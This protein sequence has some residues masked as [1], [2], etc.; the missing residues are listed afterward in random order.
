[1]AGTETTKYE[2][3]AWLR[4]KGSFAKQMQRQARAVPKVDA[5]LM[6]AQQNAK[7]L[8]VELMRGPVEAM[9]RMAKWSAVIGGAAGAFAMKGLI[10]G[11]LSFNKQMEDARLNLATMF[12]M[13]GIADGVIGQAAS[14]SEKWSTNVDIARAAMREFMVLQAQTPAGAQDLVRIYQ[15]S[16]AG[17]A[18]ANKNVAKHT[19]FVAEWSVLAGALDGDIQQLGADLGRM[20][21]GQAGAELRTWQIFKSNILEAAKGAGVVKKEMQLGDKWVQSWNKNLTAEQRF[22]VLQRFIGQAG[23]ELRKA[24]GESMG[25]LISTTKATMNSLKGVLTTPMF[26]EFRQFLKRITDASS[27]VF[28][29]EAMRDWVKIL[30]FFG[31]L[32]QGAAGKWLG[33]IERG[34]VVLRENWFEIADTVYKAFQAGALLIK[35]ALVAGAT[36]LALGAGARVVG[37]GAGAARAGIGGFRK[38]AGAIGNVRGGLDMGIKRGFLGKGRGLTGMFGSL[39]NKMFADQNV[40]GARKLAL[41]VTRMGSAFMS[42]LVIVIPLVAV[43]AALGVAV[44]AV[45]VIVAGM[46]AFL[47]DNWRLIASEIATAMREGKIKIGEVLIAAFKLWNGLKAVGQMFLGSGK[48]VDFTNMMLGVMRDVINLVTQSIIFFLDAG[49][50]LVHWFGDFT[51]ILARFFEMTASINEFA[52]SIGMGMGSAGED[53]KKQREWAKSLR[54]TTLQADNFEMRLGDIKRQFQHFQIRGLP[55][56]DMKKIADA[57]KAIADFFDASAKGKKPKVPVSGVHVENMYN[58]WDLRNTDPDRLMGAFLPKIEQLADKRVQSYEQ[59][60]QGV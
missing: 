45:A 31:T 47:I 29:T 49:M 46:T 11:G 32:L 23:P 27:G 50:S 40:V 28:G 25:G 38:V 24:F 16:A 41:A 9:A 53:A 10:S 36:K 44:G 20:L 33:A 30:T 51:N 3:A 8:G 13:F 56:P 58:T 21:T 17:L 2:V 35:A 22:K 12:Q 55:E 39:L 42:T 26:E 6:R 52:D 15:A 54:E 34:A 4:L 1:M 59:L 7:R 19:Q 5:A 18:Q 48:S 14:A 60:D 57:E 37:A 43:F